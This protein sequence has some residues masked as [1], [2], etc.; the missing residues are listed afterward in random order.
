[1][2]NISISKG[3]GFLSLRKLNGGHLNGVDHSGGP[4]GNPHGVGYQ[5]KSLCIGRTS[6]LM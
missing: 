6:Q 2:D 1:M 4:R 3:I 5:L